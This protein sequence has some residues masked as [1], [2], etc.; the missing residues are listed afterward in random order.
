MNN[1][2]TVHINTCGT[3]VQTHVGASA[4]RVSDDS[5]HS[6]CVRWDSDMGVF[7]IEADCDMHIASSQRT[8]TVMPK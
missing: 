8:I 3:I 1:V 4:A 2:G 7:V 5:G 6:I